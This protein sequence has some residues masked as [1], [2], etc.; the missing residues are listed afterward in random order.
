MF[1][2]FDLE[3][4]GEPINIGLE[5]KFKP[6]FNRFL[7]ILYYN[8]RFNG[9]VYVTVHSVAGDASSLLIWL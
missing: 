6:S 5:I 7:S 4:E 8:G 2:Q 9:G 3:Y 1:I